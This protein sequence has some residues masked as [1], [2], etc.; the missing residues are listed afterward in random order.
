[1][2]TVYLNDIKKEIEENK[3]ILDAA[4]EAGI[5]IP[6]ICFHEKLTPPGL[7]RQCVVEVEG[8]RVLLPSCITKVTDGMKIKT[9]SERVIRARRTILEMLS[10]ST[11]LSESPELAVQIEKYGADSNRFKDT[12]ERKY[13]V[14]DDNPFYMRD[15][16]KCILC[17]RC[18][19][20]CSS[21]VQF[22]YALTTTGRGYT[23]KISTFY[24]KKLPETSCVFCGNCV[25]VCPT[26]ALISSN[27]YNIKAEGA[28]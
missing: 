12:A 16:S 2:V 9:D 22:S 17:E 24:D 5:H 3:T 27:E 26:G 15:Y 13:P 20:V 21:D 14:I 11:D 25:A 7:C 23:N 4:L 10:G 1:M 28:E 6:T 19:Q 8:A 18:V